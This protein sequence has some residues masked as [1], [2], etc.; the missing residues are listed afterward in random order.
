MH[1]FG[2]PENS[3]RTNNTPLARMILFPNHFACPHAWQ[4]QGS[5]WP[6]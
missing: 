2:V 1:M 4:V 5:S 3:E 6:I